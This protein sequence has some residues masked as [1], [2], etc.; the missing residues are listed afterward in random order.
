MRSSTLLRPSL[1]F[2]AMVLQ[3]AATFLF[4]RIRSAA[5]E[6]DEAPSLRS[7]PA[8]CAAALTPSP[9]GIFFV[10]ACQPY[11]SGLATHFRRPSSASCCS[12][13]GCSPSGAAPFPALCPVSCAALPAEAPGV[14]GTSFSS[15]RLSFLFI[16]RISLSSSTRSLIVGPSCASPSFT[17]AERILSDTALNPSLAFSPARLKASEKSSLRGRLPARIPACFFRNDPA[18]PIFSS[19]FSLGGILS[20]RASQPLFSGLAT[21]FIRPVISSSSCPA[22][23]SD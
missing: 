18:L 1:A 17:P 10:T 16:W 3:A 6:T 21:H 2:S 9:W 23:A 12:A 7:W 14:S 20:E 11:F 13:V 4:S 19:T 22:P 8:F 15:G 5:A